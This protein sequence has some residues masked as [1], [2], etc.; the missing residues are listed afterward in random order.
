MMTTFLVGVTT[1]TFG[2][3]AVFFFKFWRAS[4]DRFFLLFGMASG[5]IAFERVVGLFFEGFRSGIRTPETEASSWVYLLRLS[6]FLFI[7]WAILEK[8][9]NAKKP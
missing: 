2:A 3:S 8:N 6:A 4:R 7:L 1:A 9:R 5:L